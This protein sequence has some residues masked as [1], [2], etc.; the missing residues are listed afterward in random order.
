MPDK[1]GRLT[2]ADDQKL[3]DWWT[4]HW[5]PP[6]ICPVCKSDKWTTTAHVIQMNRQAPNALFSPGITYP[7]I[8]VT[9]DPCGYAMLF[10]ATML[11]LYE[12]Y[13]APA[14]DGSEKEAD[15]KSEADV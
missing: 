4:K 9:S 1:D 6:V 12:P 11:G 3:K 7:H 8:L 5:K 13:T 15:E 10:N 14:E 2:E